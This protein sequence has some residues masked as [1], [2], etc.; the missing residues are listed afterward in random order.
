MSLTYAGRVRCTTPLRP[1]EEPLTYAVPGDRVLLSE[2]FPTLSD[3]W[4]EGGPHFT[5]TT[6]RGFRFVVAAADLEVTR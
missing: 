6:A 3:A 2:L 4:Q 5:V 1:G